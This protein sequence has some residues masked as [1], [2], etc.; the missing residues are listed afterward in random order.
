MKSFKINQS[1]LNTILLLGLGIAF[2]LASFS[3]FHKIKKTE[4]FAGSSDWVLTTDDG[5]IALKH[6]KKMHL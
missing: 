3:Y 5:D 4:G 6:K 1:E 2:L